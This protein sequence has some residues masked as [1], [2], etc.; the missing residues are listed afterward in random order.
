MEKPWTGVGAAEPE[1]DQ[2]RVIV[3]G[4]DP[5]DRQALEST[6]GAALEA[7]RAVRVDRQGLRGTLEELQRCR[8][9]GAL[10]AVIIGSLLEP[11]ELVRL[12]RALGSRK[13]T[14]PVV[15]L[16]AAP[17][18]EL[19]ETALDDGCCDVLVRGRLVSDELV[20]ALRH[21]FEISRRQRAEERLKLRLDDAR[22]APAMPA[23]A[24][25]FVSLGRTLAAA[26]HE[27]NNLLQPI[28]GYA[29]LLVGSLEPDTRAAH[30][31]RQVERSGRLASAL[32]KRLLAA[33]REAREPAVPTP[34]DARLAQ[35]AE[36]VQRV[37]GPAIELKVES[38]AREAWIAV[39]EGLLDQVMLNLAVNARD[40]LPLGGVLLLRTRVEGRASWV[41]EVESSGTN[42]LPGEPRLVPRRPETPAEIAAAAGFGLWLVR[43]LIEDAGGTVLHA[44]DTG[45]ALRL[46][47]RL[48]L[49]HESRDAAS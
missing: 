17:L 31:A 30:Y 44:D 33:G 46:T 1:F 11:R 43:G 39:Q 45:A 8:G 41:V 25:R 15:A 35:L 23:E 47:L 32:V 26:G 40:A 36:L 42:V 21:A 48:P 16:L 24:R 37:L 22:T 2:R 9:V 6:I 20:R 49:V 27:L 10:A 4:V 5:A 18:R 28:V 34:A 3:A 38:G 29:D 14:V 13:G 7:T 12:A 19:A